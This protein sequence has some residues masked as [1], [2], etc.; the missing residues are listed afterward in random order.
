VGL[1]VEQASAAASATPARLLGMA[2]R[3]GAIAVGLDADL[4]ALDDDLAVRRV[5]ARGHWV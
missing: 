3:R 2:D 4:V 1:S 5:M